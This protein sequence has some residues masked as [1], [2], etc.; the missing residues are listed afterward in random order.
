VQSNQGHKGDK[1]VFQRIP[2]RRQISRGN[3]KTIDDSEEAW[4]VPKSAPKGAPN[5]LFYVLD[6]TGFGQLT[7]YGGLVD[8][9]NFQ[10]I[11]DNG[12]AYTN[13]HTTALC[14]PKHPFFSLSVRNSC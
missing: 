1:N 9:P 8:A 3:R 11:A 12:L 14:S 6:D 13:F 7:P 4:P 2:T 10:R 5:V